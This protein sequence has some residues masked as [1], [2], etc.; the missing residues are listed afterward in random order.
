MYLYICL[1]V[2]IYIYIY[3]YIYICMYIY[4]YKYK[5][6]CI[7]IGFHHVSHVRA[8]NEGTLPEIPNVK[9]SSRGRSLAA[10]TLWWLFQS[11]QMPRIL[12][13][14]VPRHA[15]RVEAPSHEPARTR[16]FQGYIQ[17]WAVEF[18]K[19]EPRLPSYKPLEPRQGE[20]R[21]PK[22]ALIRPFITPNS[23]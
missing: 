10:S 5:Y 22:K 23:P 7:F 6:I 21:Q 12:A 4:I 19:G 18:W 17:I 14:E 2:Y 15:H 13:S 11:S 9:L 16:A 8:L 1:Y 20:P 3:R